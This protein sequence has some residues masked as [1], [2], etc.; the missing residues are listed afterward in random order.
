M[1]YSVIVAL[2]LLGCAASEPPDVNYTA[3]TLLSQTPLPSW[4]YANV[5]PD[6]ELT[7]KIRIDTG[8]SVKNVLLLTSSGDHLWDSLAASEIYAWRYAPATA[9]GQTIP[10]WIQ[11][12]MQ[13]QFEPPMLLPLAEIVCNDAAMADSIYALLVGGRSF[14]SLAGQFSVAPSRT[15]GGRLGSVDLR[16]LPQHIRASIQRLEKAGITKP[17]ELGRQYVIY[18][19][20]SASA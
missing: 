13:V 14:D 12:T 17:L 6:L 18:K 1:K 20:L 15:H 3:P 11:Q 19:R 10:M 5:V 7:V 4:P 2:L 8:G 9:N 16:T